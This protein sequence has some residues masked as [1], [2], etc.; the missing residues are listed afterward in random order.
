MAT[1]AKRIY[2][3]TNILAYVANIKAPQHQAALEI[4]RPTD[5]EILCVSSQVLAEFYS[6]IT[7][8]AI[9]ATPLQPTEAIIRIKR[10]CQMPHICLLSTPVD[11]FESWI[12]LLEERPVTNG[13]VFDLLH[14]AIML[15]HQISTIYTFNTKDFAWCSQIEAIDPS[16]LRS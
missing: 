1:E 2:L 15:A 11:L 12:A 14:I 3:D 16:K 7:N 13:G 9:L 10:I 6:Y 8:P 5:R 4:F